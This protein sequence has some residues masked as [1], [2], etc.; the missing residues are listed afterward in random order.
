M[1]DKSVFILQNK[2]IWNLCMEEIFWVYIKN[3]LKTVVTADM[4]RNLLEAPIFYIFF[5]L[6]NMKYV[7]KKGCSKF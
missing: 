2:S 6:S 4:L 3:T 1:T 7:Y 5:S